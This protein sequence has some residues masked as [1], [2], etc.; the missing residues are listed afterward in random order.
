MASDE[1]NRTTSKRK[2]RER[3]A[4]TGQVRERLAFGMAIAALWA[5]GIWFVLTH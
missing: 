1:Q 3:G 5:L 2:L 4:D